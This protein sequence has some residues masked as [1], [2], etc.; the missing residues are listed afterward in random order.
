ML[1]KVHNWLL[2][3][4]TRKL[5]STQSNWS[6]HF[7][8]ALCVCRWCPCLPHT[9]SWGH[10]A[11]IPTPA[12]Q[13]KQSQSVTGAM[14]SVYSKEG[15]AWGTYGWEV[16]KVPLYEPGVQ[17]S[18][19]VLPLTFARGNIP[20][21]WKHGDTYSPQKHSLPLT[22]TCPFDHAALTLYFSSFF[23]WEEAACSFIPPANGEDMEVRCSDWPASP[24]TG[25]LWLSV[26]KSQIFWTTP[27]RNT[28]GSGKFTPDL[29]LQSN[30]VSCS[31]PRSSC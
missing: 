20:W 7:Y 13:R 21:G 5:L 31:P 15:W 10:P 19:G 23:W 24:E 9:S 6:L 11:G 4:A 29:I 17:D 16:A 28:T 2:P 26:N 8:D 25:Q 12:S 30:Y 3:S 1:G 14:N 18:S 27:A 22:W